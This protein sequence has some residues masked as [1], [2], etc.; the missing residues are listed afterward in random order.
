M[1]QLTL[2]EII[3]PD[4]LKLGFHNG[5]RAERPYRAKGLAAINK[6]TE[7]AIRLIAHSGLRNCTIARIAQ[8]A[9]CSRGLV[10]RYFTTLNELYAAITLVTYGRFLRR[11]KSKLKKT[12]DLDLA[13]WMGVLVSEGFD[14]A[15]TDDRLAMAE[16]IEA[17]RIDHSI[18]HALRDANEIVQRLFYDL[19]FSKIVKK[20]PADKRERLPLFELFLMRAI[21]TLVSQEQTIRSAGGDEG[22][23]IE[24]QQMLR[25]AFHGELQALINEI[26]AP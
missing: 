11:L 10:Q 8:E 13:Q 18:K 20:M 17:Q 7:S 21:S 16:I 22:A 26:T 24:I 5:S 23:G 4:I 19:A 1:K 2:D 6:I 9:G 25:K 14:W 3:E 12:R 15:Q